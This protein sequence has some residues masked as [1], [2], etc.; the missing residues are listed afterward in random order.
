MTITI[1][2]K[3]NLYKIQEEFS[4]LFPF[5]KLE[6]YKK[7]IQRGIVEPRQP[8]QNMDA[9]LSEC[10]TVFNKETVVISPD[11]TVTELEK[12][13]HDIYGLSTQV[14][15]KSGNVWLVA[16]VTDNW[17]LEEQNR[18]GEM[19]TKQVNERKLNI[20]L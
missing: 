7:V 5:L 12:N 4:S 20:N 9:T 2:D 15:R 6:F 3:I 11:M 17:T 13:F 10:R 18:Q 14:F 16:T 1:N 8:I 19:I